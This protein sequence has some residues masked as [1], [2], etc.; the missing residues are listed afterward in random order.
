MHHK[1]DVMGLYKS[2]SFTVD[3]WSYQILR[4]SECYSLSSNSN[5]IK[6]KRT[7]ISYE[8]LTENIIILSVPWPFVISRFHC[9]VTCIIYFSVGFNQK[10]INLP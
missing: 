9:Y 5:I 1:S 6:K 10:K 2:E 4:Y 8:S 3:P 7:S